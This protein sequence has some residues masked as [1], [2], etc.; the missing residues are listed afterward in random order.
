MVG[1]R[2][3]AVRV[4]NSG[5]SQCRSILILVDLRVMILPLHL[6]LHVLLLLH[7]IG[8]DAF[9]ALT[10]CARRQHHLLVS[11]RLDHAR[12]NKVRVLRPIVVHLRTLGNLLLI[13]MGCLELI[14]VRR[15]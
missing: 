5:V 10:R 13:L 1:S 12:A 7:W 15:V 9:L 3:Q 8:T 11:G 6:L 2:E 4:T 14:S